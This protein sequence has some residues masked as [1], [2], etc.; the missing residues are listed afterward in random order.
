MS[1]ATMKVCPHDTIHEPERWFE[2]ERYL[3]EKAGLEIQFDISIDFPDFEEDLERAGLIYANPTDTLK[4]V[5]QHQFRALVR[6]DGRYD[7]AVLVCTSDAEASLSAMQG[8][9]LSTVVEQLPTRIALHMLE[10]QGIAPSELRD[11]TSWQA[12][13]SHLWN[14]EGQ[15]GVIYKDTYDGFSPQSKE[16]VTFVAA[17]D[18]QVA[19]HT[20]VVGAALAAQADTVQATLLAMHTDP[21]GK[22]ILESLQIPQFVAVSDA[23]LARLREVANG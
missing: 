18:E 20:V 4:L 10:K 2:L 16:M 23:E 14:G 13:V 12:V 3:E 7:E 5:D 1:A 9:P 22:A 21:Q 11:I 17:T 15:Y 19:F 8:K 6:P